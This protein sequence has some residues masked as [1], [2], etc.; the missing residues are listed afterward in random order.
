[1]EDIDEYLEPVTNHLHDNYVTGIKCGKEK[2]IKQYPMPDSAEDQLY[3][4]CQRTSDDLDAFV[5][6][7]SV[8]RSVFF[9]SRFLTLNSN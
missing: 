4:S 9:P 3:K 8:L 6:N 5:R 7:S 1:L 2:K